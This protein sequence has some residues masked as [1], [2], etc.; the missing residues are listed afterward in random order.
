MKPTPPARRRLAAS[1][2]AVRRGAGHAVG[3]AARGPARRHGR[4]GGAARGDV[5]AGP[6]RCRRG[7]G[8]AAT[9]NAPDHAQRSTAIARGPAPGPLDADRR[10]RRRAA[11]AR[12]SVRRR[13]DGAYDGQAAIK[14]LKRGMDSGALL[15]R[16]AQEQRALARLNHPHIARLFDAGLT[17]D[18]LPYFVMEL[19]DGQP[20][21]RRRAG[22]C[23]LE[24]RLRAVPA[25]GRRGGLR[26]PPAAGAPRPQA[27]QRA[28][29]RARARSSCWTS[30]SPRRC[31]AAAD[32]GGCHHASR[33]SAPSRR[34]YASPEQVRGEPVGTATDIYSLGVLL[35]R[36]SPACGPTAARPPR[37]RPAARSVLEEEPT[38]P[39]SL[40]PGPW[41]TRSGWRR[42]GAWTATWTTSC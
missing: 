21:R 10:A 37:R 36:C 23:A 3:A 5:A 7:R 1:E 20:H 31:E 34:S 24:A 16:F 4:R 29:R 17:A 26:A 19:V 41:P 11:W 9:A 15:A 8:R 25:T 28:G 22:R 27:R 14:M 12:S 32:D 13:A 33:A 38:R 30:A 35:Y 40:S 42:V 18:G 39:S 2:G 6:C